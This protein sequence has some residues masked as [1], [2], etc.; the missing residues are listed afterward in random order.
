M[1]INKILKLCE[2]LTERSDILINPSSYDVKKLMNNVNPN[3]IKKL[4]R[5]VISSNGNYYVADGFDKL[6]M[7]IETE[8]EVYN[9]RNILATFNK[10]GIMDIYRVTLEGYFN[11]YNK[12]DDYL[13][14]LFKSTEFHKNMKSIINRIIIRDF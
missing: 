4:L 6:H 7:T 8:M 1:F 11:V 14:N 13:L 3:N 12:D 10:D 2:Y 9:E 5:I